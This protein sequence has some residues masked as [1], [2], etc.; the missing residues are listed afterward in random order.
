MGAGDEHLG[1]N[2]QSWWRGITDATANRCVCVCFVCAGWHVGVG[3]YDS[4]GLVEPKGF[5]RRSVV[6]VKVNDFPTSTVD[7]FVC[8]F[9]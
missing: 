6:T 8:V 1:T 4:G 5:V 9:E 2:K 7:T 3:D